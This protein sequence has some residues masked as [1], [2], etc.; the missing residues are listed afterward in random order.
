MNKNGI[1]KVAEG[2]ENVSL[3]EFDYGETRRFYFPKS[4]KSISMVGKNIK[5]EYFDI[6]GENECFSS[7]DGVLYSKDRKTL[8]AVPN[9]YPCEEFTVPGFVENINK[10]AF[11][12][13]QL[14]KVT[15]SEGVRKI[16]SNAFVG[17]EISEIVLPDSL[18]VICGD[19]F[20]SCYNLAKSN[21]SFRLPKG[22]KEIG[23]CAFPFETGRI[24]VPKNVD[25]IEVYSDVVK[26]YFVT[27]E[28]QENI[29]GIE[30]VWEGSDEA[31]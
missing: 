10:Y 9:F 3:K 8:V 18:E 7:M 4:L 12:G 11:A 26:S 5:A 25:K 24:Y 22:I 28:K 23:A 16:E 2:T 13:S 29:Y 31:E 21:R 14:K 30:T 17:A 1:I 27:S 15:L 20:N 6:D 19:A